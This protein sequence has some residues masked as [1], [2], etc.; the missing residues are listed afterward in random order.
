MSKDAKLK[1]LEDEVARLREDCAEAYQ[2]FG[3][4][5][6]YFEDDEHKDCERVLDNLWAASC[7]EPRPHDNLL[8][9]PK[10]KLTYAP[11]GDV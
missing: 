7:G 4:L 1:R 8:P 2:A 3:N 6:F 5:A 10:G 11:E 9:W